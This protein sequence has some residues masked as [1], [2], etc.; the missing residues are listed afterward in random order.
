[1]A[2]FKKLEDM[3]V[4]G[5]RV[6]VRA[7]LNVPLRDGT[8][9]DGTRIV[10]GAQTIRELADHGARVIVCS[11]LGRPKGTRTPEFSLRPVIEPL[12]AAVGR[13]VAFANDCVGSAAELVVNGLGEGDV[14]LLEN[15]RFHGE[16]EK[17]DPEF[18]K[19]L[20][21]LADIYVN[22]AFSAAHRAHASTEYIAHLLP[23]AAGRLMQAELEALGA[24]L[25]NP[26]RPVAAIVGGAKV[27]SKIELLSNLITHVDILV[28]GGGMANT[29]LFAKG[30][31]IG[32]SLC[33]R[34]MADTARAILQKAE[35]ETGCRIVLPMDAVVAREFKE[36][37]E[38]EIVPI[39]DVPADAM[40][41]DLGPA[42]ATLIEDAMEGCNTVLW[43]GPLGAFEIRPFDKATTSV[44]RW[45]AQRTKD[46][47]FLTVAGGGDTVAALTHAGVVDDFSYV[48]AAGG[49]FLEWLEGKTLPGVA[50][51]EG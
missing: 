17:N 28:I 11:H 19:K 44:A 4:K 25:K 16:E 7:D 5:K 29:F 8:V 35:T 37:A 46:G 24:A 18:A 45:V 2:T 39:R 50:A 6:L 10:R 13:P 42:S 15:L 3:D 9:S 33:E 23:C 43:N 31:E 30:V 40:I 14:A 22:D 47:K 12:A 27:S 51:L 26:K 34:D 38:S 36:G 20:A 41:L 32:K 48:S 1:M 49:A 21:S